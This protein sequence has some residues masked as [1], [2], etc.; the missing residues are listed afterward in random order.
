MRKTLP[1]PVVNFFDKLLPFLYIYLIPKQGLIIRKGEN[2][3]P[4]TSPEDHGDQEAELQR[5]LRA[6]P[7]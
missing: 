2:H 6:F 4:M 1:Y 5:S 3:G 7:A